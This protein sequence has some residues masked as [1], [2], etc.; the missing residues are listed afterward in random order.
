MQSSQAFFTKHCRIMDWYYGKN[1]FDFCVD[2]TE[3]RRLAAILD[4]L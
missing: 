3:H 2:P 4:L 1:N